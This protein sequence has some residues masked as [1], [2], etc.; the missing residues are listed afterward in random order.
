M[1]AIKHPEEQTVLVVS[2]HGYGKRS[3]IE[4]YRI[5]NRGGKGVKTMQVTEKTGHLIDIRAV[6]ED[7]D[8]MIINKSGVAIR[9]SV[10]DIAVI[11]RATQGV[12]LIN[13]DKRG[14][15]IASV[16]SVVAEDEDEGGNQ[17]GDPEVIS[18]ADLTDGNGSVELSVE[19]ADSI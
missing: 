8:L 13:L 17:E 15:D 2:E 7:N 6:E 1:I 14:D 11:G 18:Q 12:R 4:D 16:C 5:T 19:T 10:K 3:S 9:I